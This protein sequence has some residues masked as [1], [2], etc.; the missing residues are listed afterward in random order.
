MTGQFNFD[1]KFSSFSLKVVAL[2]G[3]CFQGRDTLKVTKKIDST[4]RRFYKLTILDRVKNV[5]IFGNY[6]EH[7]C[8]IQGFKMALLPSRIVMEW[9][10]A[11]RRRIRGHPRITWKDRIRREMG[12]RNQE[13]IEW[14]LEMFHLNCKYTPMPR[15][16]LFRKVFNKWQ[17]QL[18]GG[19]NMRILFLN[20]VS[21]K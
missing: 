14:W 7:Q 5:N 16:P 19:K 2:E 1:V 13:F 3:S 17:I 21:N 18:G 15:Q 9:T 20:R 11:Q 12:E 4:H 10:P 6:S 8:W